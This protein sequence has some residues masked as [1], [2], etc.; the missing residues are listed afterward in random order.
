VVTIPSNF[1]TRRGRFLKL[2]RDVT[3]R[4]GASVSARMGIP[5]PQ[6]VVTIPSNSG[7]SRES[8]STLLRV[9]Q[10]RWLA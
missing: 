8:F 7:T 5:L 2:S 6:R 4:S 3:I 9:I 10:M 1:G